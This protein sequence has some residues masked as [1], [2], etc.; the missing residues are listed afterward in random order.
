MSDA[1]IMGA[2]TGDAIAHLVSGS[3]I[4]PVSESAQQASSIQA[5]L[6]N[7]QLY[8]YSWANSAA[9]TGQTGMR[10]GDTAYQQDS[11]QPYWYLGSTYGW[12]PILIGH[13]SYG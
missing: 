5:A 2:T 9:R 8:S 6:S 12:C 13:P 7:R 4:N 3:P 11:D 1:A 10:E